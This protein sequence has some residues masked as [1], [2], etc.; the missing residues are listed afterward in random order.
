MVLGDA[1]GMAHTPNPSRRSW[2]G[3]APTPFL[4]PRPERRELRWAE[5]GSHSSA[6]RS[7]VGASS[8]GGRNDRDREAN[9]QVVLRCR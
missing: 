8:I 7:G 9:V 1:G 2:V 5:A 6:R 4:T 3:P